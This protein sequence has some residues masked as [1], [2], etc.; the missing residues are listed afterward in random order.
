MGTIYMTKR[1]EESVKPLSTTHK[2]FD[3]NKT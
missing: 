2:V 1:R 3:S